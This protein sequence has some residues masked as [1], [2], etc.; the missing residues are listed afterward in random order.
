[1]TN[2]ENFNY[3]LGLNYSLPVKNEFKKENQKENHISITTEQTL[4]H[5][6]YG[7]I[8]VTIHGI[9]NDESRTSVW[10]FDGKRM[11]RVFEKITLDQAITEAN[12][13]IN[14]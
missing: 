6:I 14:K 2:T 4:K 5:N 8:E 7:N 1:M 10:T 3:S 9:Y 11:K 13:L 12:R